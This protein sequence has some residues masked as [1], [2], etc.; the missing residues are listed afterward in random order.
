MKEIILT[1]IKEVDKPLTPNNIAEGFKKRGFIEVEPIVGS[2]LL[3]TT[4][5]TY[6]HTSTIVEIINANTFRTYNSI[7]HWEYV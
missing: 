7:Y 4:K 2:I 6:F 1:K 5:L 3:I